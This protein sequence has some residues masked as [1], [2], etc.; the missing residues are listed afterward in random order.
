MKVF[1]FE[2]ADYRE[3]Y[4]AEGYLH[5]EQGVDPEFLR[6]LREF[7]AGRFQ[8]HLVEGRAIGG[9]KSQ[10]LYEF[11]PEVDYR[12][13]VLDPIATLCGLRHDTMTLS[14]RHIK[15]YDP[16]APPEPLPHKDRYASQA[17][18]GL[19]IEVPEGSHLVVYPYDETDLNPYNV[20]AAYLTSLPPHRRPEVALKSA[21]EIV[22][23]DKPG[24]VMVFPGN[25]LWHLR[26][27]PA[28]AVNLY[29]KVNDFDCDPLGEDPTTAERRRATLA[30]AADADGRVDRLVPVLSRRL[31]TISRE[32]MRDWQ[33][34]LQARLWDEGPVMIDDEEFRLLSA[35]DGRR[36]VVE[37]AG[38][39][40]R[41]ALLR[42]AQRGVVDL[43]SSR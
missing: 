14:E 3:Q 1:A 10:S 40:Q 39:A 24:D 25:R 13:D 37:L 38:D 27:R 6:V 36:K 16:E 26:R 30:R 31:D 28:R 21:R 17:S 43:V 29:L 12:R 41:A 7:A 22:V 5:I 23:Y 33:E 8:A 4:V 2:P 35:V 15:A 11:P 20:S 32:Y 19:S 18:V 34:A 42:L 9:R